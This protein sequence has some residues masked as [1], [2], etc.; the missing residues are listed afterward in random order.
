MAIPMRLNT[1]RRSPVATATGLPRYTR[2]DIVG[3]HERGLLFANHLL[4]HFHDL[5]RNLVKLVDFPAVGCRHLHQLFQGF[6]RAT[7]SQSE[8]MSLQ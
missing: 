3:T 1:R 2:N 8:P 6:A 4:H 7:N 5:R